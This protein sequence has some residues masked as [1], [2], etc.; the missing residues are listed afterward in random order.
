MYRNIATSKRDVK[1][2]THGNNILTHLYLSVLR[3][4]LIYTPLNT[5]THFQKGSRD[6]TDRST[7]PTDRPP[8]Q[9]T[10]IHQR[11]PVG[12]SYECPTARVPTDRH[13]LLQVHII[14][15]Q[16]RRRRRARSSPS[17]PSPSGRSSA[18]EQPRRS[19]QIIR[20][21]KKTRRGA[22]RQRKYVKKKTP[23]Q[24]R[25]DTITIMRKRSRNR[26]QGIPQQRRV[27]TGNRGYQ[28]KDVQ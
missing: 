20:T 24:I 26:Q 27:V 7:G 16:N 23:Q 13:F 17:A 1:V 9:P 22:A 19:C 6:P 10:G 3:E 4:C 21:R 15:L 5:R 14:P 8:N 12:D 25:G 11:T 18:G 28:N 2:S